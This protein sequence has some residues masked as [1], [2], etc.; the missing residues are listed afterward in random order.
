[1]R[2]LFTSV[3]LILLSA[4][5]NSNRESLSRKDRTTQTIE[6]HSDSIPELAFNINRQT[7][8]EY[9]LSISQISAAIH[10]LVF[11]D[12]EESIFVQDLDTIHLDFVNQ[13][14]ELIRIPLRSIASW[15]SPE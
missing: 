14:G 5:S 6:K 1:M 13:Q 2:V 11:S 3:F 10:E 7:V 12:R 8:R 15:E 9:G 4:C